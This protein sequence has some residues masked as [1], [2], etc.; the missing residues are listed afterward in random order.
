MKKKE[1]ERVGILKIMGWRQILICILCCLLFS[2][3]LLLN[4]R[5]LMQLGQENA[6]RN[7]Q[8]S[9]LLA[10]VELEDYLRLTNQAVESAARRIE[11]MRAGGETDAE[12]LAYM[13]RESGN[14]DSKIAGPT[15]A[16]YGYIGGTFLYGGDWVPGAD[17]VATTRPWY[18]KA[19]EEGGT[20]TH[21][22]PYTDAVT[23]LQTITV[24]KVLSDGVSVVAMDLTTEKL[25]HV[26]D[27]LASSDDYLGG[28]GA[29]YGYA[30]VFVIDSDG[31]IIAHS[32]ESKQLKVYV[33]SDDPVEREIARQ[34]LE[35][36][37]RF[38]RLDVD[39]EPI[40]YCGGEVEGGWYVFSGMDYGKVMSRL[41]RNIYASV[42]AAI[43]GI[44]GMIAV[45]VKISLR[46][47]HESIIRDYATE[48][49]EENQRLEE[50]AAA[51]IRIAELTQSVSSL[52][53][54]M[55]GMMFSKDVETGEYLAC[56]QAFADYASQ[57]SV[58]DVIGKTDRELFGEENAEKFVANDKKALSMDR[59][60][61]YYE[62]S[63]N[64]A[65]RTYQLQTT[66]LKF[67]DATGRRC[68]LGVC[69]DFTE[70]VRVRQETAEARKAYEKA[71]S[72]GE[73]YAGI[74]K[75]LSA[76]YFAL[77]YV[78]VESGNYVSYQEEILGN[79]SGTDFF[80]SSKKQFE[81]TIVEEDRELFDRELEKNNVCRIVREHGEMNLSYRIRKDGGVAY[82]KLRVFPLQ[83]DTK[84]LIF[85]FA[86]DVGLDAH[87]ELTGLRTEAALYVRGK[88]LLEAHPEGWCLITLDLEHFRLFNEW[89]GRDAGDELLRQI[90]ERMTR[91]EAK[92][93]GLACYL[94]QDDFVLI[95]PYDEEGVRRL[96]EDVHE[97]VME[98]GT[99]VGF[100]PA[101]G[102]CMEENGISVE[103]MFDRA[104]QASQ[105]A[106]EDYHHRIR[107]FEESMFQ[108]TERDYQI[109]SDFRLAIQNQE[110]FIQLQPQCNIDSGRVV[111]A[112]SLVR[113]KKAD[114]SMVSPGIFVPVLEQYGFV[115]DL[116]QFVW[117]EVCA[118]QRRW[119]D[120]GHTPL[121]VSVNVSQ[122][123]IFTIDVPS[124]FNLLL[125]KYKL[126]VEVIKIE[127]TES[128]YVGDDK[129]A[130]TVRRLREKGFLVLMDDFG[131]GYS[132]L[133]MLRTL[134][135]DIIKLD[136]KFLR[137][138]S[139]DLKGVHILESIVGMAKS[140]EAPII[141][142]GVETEEETEFIKKLGCHYVQGYH[143]YRPMPVPDFEALI[144]D[145][146]N[147]DTRG[148]IM[149]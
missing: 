9:Y 48:V 140:M 22:P 89:Y 108:K 123:D 134:S 121:P 147:I 72:A 60:Y 96:F 14:L 2:G 148:Y 105:H 29:R 130:D 46:R 58:E 33:G 87:S 32:D 133:N 113:W 139:D 68:L 145:T 12:I 25:Q 34:I 61:S 138:N 40:I 100:M 128:A 91:A 86:F 66:K 45:M 149:E 7:C 103:E 18:I 95:M 124:Y 56:N 136:A 109:L 1:A 83:G 135:V 36:K 70:L 69:Q 39:G 122:I 65:G 8:N 94:G 17:F 6:Y 142:E 50:K 85:G 141:V 93:D 110:L 21:V 63:K 146:G 62:E 67:A 31:A 35:N 115:T 117:E 49:E 19:V 55:P 52:L 11:E 80:N 57:K 74:A 20:V 112:E 77:Y 97:L 118:W 81:P 23:G 84:H 43:V 54:N 73:L 44:A 106:K 53:E 107:I 144:G 137:M 98:H 92:T 116:D 126:P 104:L 125:W 59:P 88:E 90:G 13:T 64:A 143:F 82:C 76:S 28:D 10:S 78:E 47:Y 41:T 131:S 99:S 38:F 75:A 132:S 129:V 26:V 16:V 15:T 101:V 119:I 30:Q 24:C 120:G 127:I 4:L 114:G 42:A 111:G 102:V 37:Q 51:A 3:M 5:E 71:K 79:E 27:E